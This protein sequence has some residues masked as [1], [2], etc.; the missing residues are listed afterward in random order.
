MTE[1]P[2][3]AQSQSVVRLEGCAMAAFDPRRFPYREGPSR[4][5]G[6][7]AKPCASDGDEQ[8]LAAKVA[9]LP[10]REN[11]GYFPALVEMVK[12]DLRQQW[13]QGRRPGVESYLR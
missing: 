4:D 11:G 6:P 10:S 2:L 13:L 12:I 3:P 5:E 7:G 1:R 9:G 8:R